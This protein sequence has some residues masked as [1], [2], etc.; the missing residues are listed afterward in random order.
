MEVLFFH[1]AMNIRHSHLFASRRAWPLVRSV[2]L[3]AFIGFFIRSVYLP[4]NPKDREWKDGKIR[5]RFLEPSG[6]ADGRVA[7]LS[8]HFVLRG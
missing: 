4:R 1:P 5:V 8:A 3:M 7:S 6:K 2:W